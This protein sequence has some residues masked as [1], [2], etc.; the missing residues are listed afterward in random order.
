LKTSEAGAH[1]FQLSESSS[2]ACLFPRVQVD[3]LSSL[4]FNSYLVDK[5][6]QNFPF[7]TFLYPL[8]LVI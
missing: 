4:V 6:G 7:F 5:T 2:A 3:S 8:N 1:S